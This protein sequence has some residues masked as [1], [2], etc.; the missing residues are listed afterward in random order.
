MEN[1]LVGNDKK[2]QKKK[3]TCWSY[4]FKIPFKDYRRKLSSEIFQNI[5]KAKKTKAF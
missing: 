3:I 2:N 1:K 4:I 5:L